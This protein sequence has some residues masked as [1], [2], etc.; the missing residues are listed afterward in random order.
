MSYTHCNHKI[1]TTPTFNNANMII[2][3]KLCCRDSSKSI[4]YQCHDGHSTLCYEIRTP[5]HASHVSVS[6]TF[7]AR[8]HSECPTFLVSI[9]SKFCVKLCQNSQIIHE[10]HFDTINSIY[11]KNNRNKLMYKY[12]DCPPVLDMIIR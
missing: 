12:L 2:G 6:D 4:K 9:F 7:G 1:Q 3:C 8:T 10:M 11:P 5:L